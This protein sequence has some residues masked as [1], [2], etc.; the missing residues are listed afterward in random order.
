MGVTTSKPITNFPKELRINIV[1]LSKI[2]YSINNNKE[3]TIDRYNKK[4]DKCKRLFIYVRPVEEYR[5][6]YSDFIKSDVNMLFWGLYTD[7]LANNFSY[8]EY[9]KYYERMIEYLFKLLPYPDMHQDIMLIYIINIYKRI[10]NNSIKKLC[11][12]DVKDIIKL[13]YKY[14]WEEC[15]KKVPTSVTEGWGQSTVAYDS[16]RLMGTDSR[17]YQP[18]LTDLIKNTYTELEKIYFLENAKFGLSIFGSRIIIDRSR[19]AK[20]IDIIGTTGIKPT[21]KIEYVDVTPRKILD[22]VTEDRIINCPKSISNDKYQILK[23]GQKVIYSSAEMKI[24]SIRDPDKVGGKECYSVFSYDC[25]AR[26]KL[27]IILPFL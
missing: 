2:S 23:N 6:V 3:Y 17:F 24:I 25:V 20:I 11:I 10:N 5:L 14:F 1:E 18:F 27:T 19:I 4:K 26:D 21:Y 15:I 16:I 13:F 8:Q 9:T 22:N 7:K 12:G